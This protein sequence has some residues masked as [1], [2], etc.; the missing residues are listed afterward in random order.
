MQIAA[1]WVGC[2]GLML[3]A[4]VAIAALY[5]RHDATTSLPESESWREL[6]YRTFVMGADCWSTPEASAHG[7]IANEEAL[8]DCMDNWEG[9]FAVHQYPGEPDSLSTAPRKMVITE[10]LPAS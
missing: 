2:C 7:R 1:R 3:G 5:A 4:A 8:A 6:T 10:A 9:N